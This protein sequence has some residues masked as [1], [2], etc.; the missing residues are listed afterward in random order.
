M[1]NFSLTSLLAP[2]TAG[3]AILLTPKI[4][5]AQVNYS[6]LTEVVK[7]CQED[8]LSP[9][10]F[11][12]I[13]TDVSKFLPSEKHDHISSCILARYFYSLT[14]SNLPQLSSSGEIFP[15]YP[16]DVAV[17]QTA[18]YSQTNGTK[19]GGFLECIISRDSSSQI[20][21]IWSPISLLAFENIFGSPSFSYYEQN[22]LLYLVYTC[23]SCVN[24]DY[25]SSKKTMI[26]AFINWFFTLDKPK[27]RDVVSILG[28]ESVQFYRREK[29]YKEAL[30]AVDK[31]KSARQRVE[32]QER[33]QRQREVLGE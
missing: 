5:L 32:Q 20:C 16:G 33:E 10:Y 30:S 24:A 1:K 15:G 22:N 11:K 17:S 29:I 9:E 31:Y 18:L 25:L 14:L 26:D 12:G 2:L 6:F 21:N 27:R 7:S 4:S 28:N 19:E 3:I 13:S 8:A 23:P